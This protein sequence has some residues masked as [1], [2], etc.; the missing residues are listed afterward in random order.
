MKKS[1]KKLENFLK[2]LKELEENQNNI[3]EISKF[4]D[5]GA[6]CLKNENIKD[7][8]NNI[9]EI[10]KKRVVSELWS[11]AKDTLET[12]FDEIKQIQNRLGRE[13]NTI[14]SL[15][16]IMKEINVI[17]DNEW[18]MDLKIDPVLKMY[19]VLDNYKKYIEITTAE[20]DKRNNI[21]SEWA[22][23]LETSNNKFSELRSIQ[24]D[25]KSKLFENTTQFK[26]D[27]N[28]FKIQYDNEGP[29]VE[30][31]S[32]KDAAERLKRFKEM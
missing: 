12:L 30:G 1:E 20:V 21:K 18:S 26:V 9:I 6:M 25:I 8:L 15:V 16:S 22:M 3:Q 17:R 13:Y 2:F 5:I 19:I 27:L 4:K 14:E 31:I 29:N 11:I 23:L 7:T 28:N 10:I 32:P 24:D